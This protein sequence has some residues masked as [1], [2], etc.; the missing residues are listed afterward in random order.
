MNPC[1]LEFSWKLRFSASPYQRYG[2][3]LRQTIQRPEFPMTACS[4]PVGIFASVSHFLNTTFRPCPVCENLDFR[5][6]HHIYIEVP[7][8]LRPSCPGCSILLQSIQIQAPVVLSP[9][10]GLTGS[11]TISIWRA[12]DRGPIRV[13]H[14]SYRFPVFQIFSDP[15]VSSSASSVSCF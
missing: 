2:R 11:H 3:Y 7:D 1:C 14:T 10:R 8:E 5:P 6:F 15:Y 12:D 9:S 13:T 4:I